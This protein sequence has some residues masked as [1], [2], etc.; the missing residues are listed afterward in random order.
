MSSL[1]S[2]DCF[3]LV[4]AEH[5]VV[6][7]GEFSNVIERAKVGA[8]DDCASKFSRVCLNLSIKD[9]SATLEPEHRQL[10]DVSPSHLHSP[11]RAHTHTRTCR[12][13][14]ARVHTHTGTDTHL[15]C[16]SNTRFQAA[17]LFPNAGLSRHF[18]INICLSPH[19]PHWLLLTRFIMNCPS[20]RWLSFTSDPL[21]WPPLQKKDSSLI[22]VYLLRT[23]TFRQKETRNE[24]QPVN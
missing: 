19:P 1:N 5:C 9:T 4:T 11:L 18:L 8:A 3:L 2:G 14:R 20:T 24:L 6:W 12:H 15:C 16:S 17:P 7:I 23:R 10:I 13:A 21:K 22:Y